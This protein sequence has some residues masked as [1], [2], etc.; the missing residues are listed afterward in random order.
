MFK[1][2][3]ALLLWMALFSVAVG[4]SAGTIKSVD[5][6]GLANIGRTVIDATMRTRVGQPYLKTLIDDDKKAIMDLGYFQAVDVR[7]Q[8][9]E[10]QSWAVTVE[11]VEFPKIKEVRIVGNTVIPTKAILDVLKSAPSVPIAPDNVFCLR[12]QKPSSDA[13]EKLY[14]EKG[15]FARVSEFGPLTDAPEVVSLTILEL[16]VNSI[17]VQGA[18][19][20]RQSVLDKIIKTRSGQ[21][22]NADRWRKDNV[23]LLNTRWFDKVEPVARETDDV[24][25]V[26]LIIDVTEART[27]LFNIGFQMDP[28]SS[29]AGMV[30]FS[31]TNFRGSGQNYGLDF[32]QGTQG[33][34]ASIDLNY[35]NPYVDDKGTGI[36][37]NLYSRNVYRFSN[38]FGGSNQSPT[39]ARYFERH[40]GGSV[41]LTRQLKEDSK[42]L[43][44]GLRY[45]Q[46]KTTNLDTTNTTGFI[47]QDGDLASISAAYVVNRRDLDIDPSRGDW[48]RMQIEPGWSRITKVGG[49]TNDPSLIGNHFF[50]RGDVEYRKYWSPQPPREKLDDPR[51]V[52]AFRAHVGTVGGTVP[53]FEQFFA[54]GA[55]TIRGYP[56]DRFWGKNMAILNLEYRHPIQKS[57]NM[58]AFVDYGGAWGGFGTVNNYTQSKRAEFKLGYGLG[59]SFR[60]PLGPIRLDFGFNQDGGSRTHFMIGTSF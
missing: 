3:A 45:E 15:F 59:F 19:R 49:D 54:G 20:T 43:S 40:T 22:F 17:K 58:I 51:R 52:F 11:V 28:R 12:S 50:V 24:S 8:E 14:S 6:K 5:V 46:I 39:D 25:R 55:N 16:T 29:F 18:T 38:T 4:Q 9:T 47:Q 41:A 21:P 26:D 31:D 42:F 48:L 1:G 60:T 30:R 35:G 33:G 53:F 34:G 44:T 36:N 57:F 37:Y 13:I 10:A 7:A 32:I 23:A 2:V 27:G 56:E